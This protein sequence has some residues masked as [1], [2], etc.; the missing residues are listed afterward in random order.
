MTSVGCETAIPSGGECRIAAVGRCS[1]CGRA[2][3][4]THR[5]RALTGAAYT[6]F[7]K[8]CLAAE[9]AAKQDR[10][11]HEADIRARE[12]QQIQD[13]LLVLERAG[14]GPRE[15]C[16]TKIEY[17]SFGRTSR[18]VLPLEPAW[19]VGNLSWKY[20]ETWRT[21]ETVEQ[22]PTGI[23]RDL[24]LVRMDGD[25][26]GGTLEAWSPHS[27]DGPFGNDSVRHQ[28]LDALERMIAEHR[29]A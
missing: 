1:G 26:A 17:K 24:D 4:D 25:R 9:E 11:R 10:L 21:G 12:R 5:A 18:K 22:E 15:R 19:P 7:C 20:S 23:T 8:L 13:H 6:D 29:P 14:V 16:T 3:C 27:A 28:V 2:F